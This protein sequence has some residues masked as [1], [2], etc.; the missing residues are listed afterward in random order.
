MTNRIITLYIAIQCDQFRILAPNS[1]ISM[2]MFSYLFC[3]L[4]DLLHRCYTICIYN[5]ITMTVF[6]YLKN[7][8]ITGAP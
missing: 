3:L 4:I 1:Y 8:L 6:I 2:A 7:Y 5:C